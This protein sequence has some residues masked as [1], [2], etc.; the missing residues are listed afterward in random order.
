M[1]RVV[2]GGKLFPAVAETIG[3][4]NVATQRSE[5][6]WSVN[7]A[8]KLFRDRFHSNLEQRPFPCATVS[9]FGITRTEPTLCRFFSRAESNRT[10]PKNGERERIRSRGDLPVL[11]ERSNSDI[12][13]RLWVRFDARD[14]AYFLTRHARCNAHS[15]GCLSSSDGSGSRASGP[16]RVRHLRLVLS[17]ANETIRP[18]GKISARTSKLRWPGDAN[19]THRNP[20]KIFR[21]QGNDDVR[22]S[23]KSVPAG[24][25]VLIKTVNNWP[26]AAFQ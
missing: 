10:E 5:T 17:S 15:C 1:A 7:S 4:C 26:F 18:K 8:K 13:R 11:G 14:I 3:T 19:T 20:A 6:K 22:S 16:Y 2:I 21:L 25:S 23:S 9:G 24:G 12:A